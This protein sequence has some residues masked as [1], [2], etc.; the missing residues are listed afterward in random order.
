MLK[1]QNTDQCLLSKDRDTFGATLPHQQLYIGMNHLSR[2]TM[3]AAKDQD[4]T[5]F[6][7]KT[8]TSSSLTR[9]IW[10]YLAFSFEDTDSGASFDFIA[11]VDKDYVHI[12]GSETDF[13]IRDEKSWPIYV[14]A[15]R[16]STTSTPAITNKLHGFI[17][18]ISIW[19]K[20]Y[21]GETDYYTN[22]T[23]TSCSDFPC[24]VI[25]N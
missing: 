9:D 22:G 20:K 3:C 2:L 19:Q 25:S 14:A 11:K 21:S 8:A 1:A 6:P 7:C 15:Y 23:C 18:M 4:T 13:L 5:V 10:Y 17:T 12:T 24:A 16:N